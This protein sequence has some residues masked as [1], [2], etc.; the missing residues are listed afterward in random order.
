M[1]AEILIVDD[2]AFMRMMLTDILVEKGYEIAGESEDGEAALRL[3]KELKPDLV[4]MDII[5]PG[6]GGIKSIKEILK[7]DPKA[8][9]LVVSALGQQALVKEAIEAGAKGF[10]VKPF[11]PEKVI[12]EVENILGVHEKSS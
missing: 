4:T 10:V 1:G 5:M 2:A 9:I 6:A 11:R 3:Y 7:T 12:E 8:K